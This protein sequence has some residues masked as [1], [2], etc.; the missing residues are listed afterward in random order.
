MKRT[1]AFFGMVITLLLTNGLR[2][3]TAQAPASAVLDDW[4]NRFR[5]LGTLVP[6]N[7]LRTQV[8]T[9]PS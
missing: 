7:A 1:L 8:R 5:L 9:T 4:G 6:E 2:Q 3:L